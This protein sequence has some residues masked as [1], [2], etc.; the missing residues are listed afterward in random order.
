[1][2][3]TSEEP[4]TCTL[5]SCGIGHNRHDRS[6]AEKLPDEEDDDED[7]DEDDEEES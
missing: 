1:M 6:M 5:R 3:M 7:I 2:P 4:Q